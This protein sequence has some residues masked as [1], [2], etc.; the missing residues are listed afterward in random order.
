MRASSSFAGVNFTSCSSCSL[1]RWY[2]WMHCA[3]DCCLKAGSDCPPI[4]SHRASTTR[5][6]SACAAAGSCGNV[7]MSSMI[8][9]HLSATGNAPFMQSLIRL[10]RWLSACRCDS[11]AT[12]FLIRVWSMPAMRK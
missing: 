5:I 10:A 11:V 12:L 7:P 2:A 1:L 6:A 4:V 9:E 3:M 8:I